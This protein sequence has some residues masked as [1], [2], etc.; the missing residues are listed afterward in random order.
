MMT[1]GA[2]FD[3]TGRLWYSSVSLFRGGQV[4]GILRPRPLRESGL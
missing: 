4:V 1:G 2:C 3:K